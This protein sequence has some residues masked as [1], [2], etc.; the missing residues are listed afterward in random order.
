MMLSGCSQKWTSEDKGSH[1][2]ITQRKG[3]TLGYSVSSGVQILTKG[4]YA[5]KDLNRNGKLDV[6]EDWRKPVQ[7]RA[8]DLASQMSVEQIA[9][10]M[11]Y[12]AHQAVPTEQISEAQMKFL[13]EDNLR[14]VLV[15]RVGSPEIA[16]KWSN[17]VQA[18]V[19]GIGLGIPANNSSDP[20]HS[21]G[22]NVEYYVGASG[23]I[24]YWPSS[25][26]IAA[27]FDPAV[28]E[29]FGKI[30]SE[31]YRALGIATALSPQ[32]DIATEP[33]WSRFN[34]TFGEDP[35]LST[36]MARA[37]VDG[38]QTS[39]GDAEIDGGWGFHSVNAMIKHWP[40]GG[41]G[42]GGRD[43]HYS[44]GKYAVFPGGRLADHMQPFTEGAFK[45]NGKTGM[46]TAVMPYYTIS[47]DIDKK[48]GENVGNAFS[49]YLINDVLRGEYGFEGVVCTDWGVTKD[50]RA[51]NSFGTT[52]WGVEHLSVAERHYKL[53][54]AGVDMFGG[55][56]DK[57]PV[58]EAYE[59]GVKEMGEEW[60]R[61]RMEKTAVRLLLN[62]FRLGLFENPYLDV[63]D[64][65]A[66][67]GNP[68]F[69]KAGYDAQLRSIVM[70]KNKG[71]V[72]PLAEKAK[73]YVPEVWVAPRAAFRGNMG[74]GARAQQP[75][76]QPK[77]HWEM[78][79]PVELLSKYFTVV[80]TPAEADFAIVFV[81]AP[82]NGTGYDPA[83]VAKGGNGYMPISLQYNDYTATH[84][85]E[86]SLAGGD[87]LESFTNRSYKGKTVK[88]SNKDQL[89]LILKTRRQMGSKPVIVQ[90]DANRPMVMSEFEGVADAILF[91]FSVQKQAILDILSGKAEPSG[92]LP[93]Q[94]PADMQTVEEQLEDVTR[95][96]RCHVDSEG[97][98]YDF[99]FGMNWKGVI[100]DARTEKYK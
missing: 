78:P 68:D 80:K 86:V 83:D 7:Q 39:E 56:N 81:D 3:A 76:Q 28:M 12:S 30:A 23:D 67:V 91:G 25:L 4:G 71:G 34:G 58:L 32:I 65:K 18:Y 43:A 100:N 96:M 73:V 1:I 16:A 82:A 19:E 24:S 2:E 46:A 99:A 98:T 5:F 66:T 74:A 37:Y 49:E 72:L 90:V 60:M 40:G 54:K 89:D 93:M 84:A 6:Y 70:L 42:E 47:T 36:D 88:T 77:G 75:Q 29:Q 45:L 10:L 50:N 94:L 21:A 20:R 79:V 97:N 63:E 26:G 44:Y 95:D 27:T 31:E 57:D 61:A 41:A 14:H 92:L 52:S 8:E 62:V 38:F 17:N 48:N 53:I 51:V 11:L 9:G 22:E 13:T 15:T 69:M 55:N 85:R 87:P 35:D 33:R 64:T 59:M